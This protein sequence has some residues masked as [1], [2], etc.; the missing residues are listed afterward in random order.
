MTEWNV[1]TLSYIVYIA[2]K[3]SQT[4]NSTPSL[5]CLCDCSSICCSSMEVEE[6]WLPPTTGR[7]GPGCRWLGMVSLTGY[8]CPRQLSRCLGSLSAAVFL[9]QERLHLSSAW[10]QVS[11]FL[12][13]CSSSSLEGVGQPG[14]TPAGFPLLA[15]LLPFTSDP[16]SL[17][18][19]VPAAGREGDG[20]KC[21]SLLKLS[22]SDSISVQSEGKLAMLCAADLQREEQKMAEAVRQQSR[23]AVLI[24][25][26]WELHCF[27]LLTLH[28]CRCWHTVLDRETETFFHNKSF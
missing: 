1:P 3:S 7:A 13:L 14:R 24:R 8:W 10:Q 17:R 12:L 6:G 26:F 11:F 27:T 28:W 22:L 5:P 25:V 20:R 16:H 19:E 21:Q 9:L 23:E 4:S 18:S 15:V 2:T